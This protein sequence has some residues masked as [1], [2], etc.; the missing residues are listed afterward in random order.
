MCRKELVSTKKCLYYSKVLIEKLQQD[1]FK[2][3]DNHFM[4]IQLL[5]L[6][7][8]TINNEMNELPKSL[9]KRANDAQSAIFK[10]KTDNSILQFFSNKS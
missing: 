7:I 10:L 9:T 2:A 3:P 4:P 1:N 5:K 6:N 8:S